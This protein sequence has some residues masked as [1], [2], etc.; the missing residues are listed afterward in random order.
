MSEAAPTRA[1]ENRQE[2]AALCRMLTRAS[3]FRLGFA[4]ANHPS[5]R[6]RIAQDCARTCGVR[7]REITLDEQAP[8]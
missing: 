3:G 2:L 7:P 6:R 1:E 4:V 8:E 5:L